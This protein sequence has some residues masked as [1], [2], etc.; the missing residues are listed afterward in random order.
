MQPLVFQMPTDK[1]EHLLNSE[2][3]NY[4]QANYPAQIHT[5]GGGSVSS[6]LSGVMKRDVHGQHQKGK[7]NGRASP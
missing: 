3:V 6:I 2:S 7:E 1:V 4:K 5:C